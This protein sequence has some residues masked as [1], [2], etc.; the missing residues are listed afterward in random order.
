MSYIPPVDITGTIFTA[1]QSL[2]VETPRP[3]FAFEETDAATDNKLW[4]IEVNGGI[5][6]MS[7][8]NNA[9]SASESFLVASRV[10]NAVKTAFGEGQIVLGNTTP[11]AGVALT[12]DGILRVLNEAANRY[13]A[14]IYYDH[15]NQWGDVTAYDDTGAV[16]LPATI[17][18]S[19]LEM[20]HNGAGTYGFT[21]DVNG[22]KINGSLT[23][24]YY[25]PQWHTFSN[26][27]TGWGTSI[28]F[29]MSYR[30]IGDKV[31]IEGYLSNS[32]SGTKIGT[33]PSGHWPALKKNFDVRFHNTFTNAW[34]CGLLE[35]QDDGDMFMKYFNVNDVA[36]LL[37]VD[38][39]EFSVL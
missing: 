15:G 5:L 14:D 33:L 13:R 30:K 10:L 23:G 17:K 22:L 28:K 9:K 32:G 37:S 24:P 34:E 6:A 19:V 31:Q 20:K 38:G 11:A 1:R 2:T 26:Y 21:S 29:D 25:W 36:D 27:S 12:V 16:Y 39:I 3:D 8:Y 35:I 7:A 18:S 4:V